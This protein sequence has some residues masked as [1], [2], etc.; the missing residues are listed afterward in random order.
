MSKPKFFSPYSPKPIGKGTDF[1]GQDEVCNQLAAE[2]C[3]IKK[4]LYDYEA[5]N[6][7][8]LPVIRQSTYNDVDITPQSYEAAKELIDKVNSD[9][10]TLPKETQRQ[11]GT[12]QNYLSDLPKLAKNDPVTMQ[13]YSK[14]R[15]SGSQ[16]TATTS[17]AE[18]TSSSSLSRGDSEISIISGNSAPDNGFAEQKGVKNGT[19]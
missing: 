2:E 18:G 19:N 17:E 8:E 14:F 1:T 7:N 5:G 16:D 6:I 9:F 4:L 11:F 3:E 15:V 10:A 12:I 13:K